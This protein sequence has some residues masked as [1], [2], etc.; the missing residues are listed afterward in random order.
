[1][2]FITRLV[3][4]LQHRAPVEDVPSDPF[5]GCETIVIPGHRDLTP[6]NKEKVAVMQDLLGLLHDDDVDK[7]FVD[8]VGSM[9]RLDFNFVGD[10]YSLL[11]Q[12][13]RKHR[14]SQ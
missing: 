5:R 3:R 12:I 11:S 2:E 13:E 7:I 8:L 10:A 1:M 4:F 14:D 9:T 6:A